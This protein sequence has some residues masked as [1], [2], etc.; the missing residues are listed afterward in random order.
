MNRYSCLLSSG[1]VLA[2]AMSLTHPS[3]AASHRE[4]P[5]I[6]LDPSADITDVYAFRN[7]ND[8]DK[9]VFIMNVI[10]AQEPSSGPNY[11]NFDDNVLYEIHLDTNRNGI[12]EDIV[13]QFR[14]NTEIR[15][16]F[17]D[18]PLSYAANNNGPG[19]PPGI[20]ALDGPGSKSLGLRQHYSVIE[21]RGNKRRNLGTGAMFT[22]PSNIGPRTIP[23]Y[24]KLT[25]QGIYPLK[26]GGRVFSGQRDETFYI[27]LGAAF[28]T[29]NF[30][31]PPI[32]NDAQDGDDSANPFGNDM[33]SGFNVNTIAIEV[34]IR[35]IT[36]DS[37]AVI[38]MYA[39]TSRQRF[40]AL[41]S[42]GSS[43]GFG[44]FIQR[45]R[46]ANPLVN[47]LLI[48]TGQK[49]RWNATNP[50]QE[51][52][53]VDFFLNPRPTALINL[54]FGTNFPT[55]NRTDLIAALLK[56]PGQDPNA[57]SPTNPCSELL[58]LD[59]AVAPTPPE[60]QQRLGGLA[61]DAAGF[62]NGRRPND[63]VTDIVLRVVAG[64]L[65]G[66]VPR[67]GDGVN[68][69]IGAMGSNLTD[70]GIYTVFPFLPT[71]HD[72]RNRQHIDCDEAGAN[73]CD[74][75]SSAQ[76]AAASLP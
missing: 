66:S 14:F 20:V 7:W 49:D 29:L 74:P 68:F 55:S 9:V 50:A 58:R 4:A 10:P 34:P 27:D 24:E 37:D 1:A 13:Y 42:D 33:F 22:V 21:K 73:P 69:N 43:R 15:E 56:Y 41:I 31:A 47:E 30:R 40:Q 5:A 25:D 17:K 32:L 28:D 38:G 44:P 72:G 76:A 23:D 54:V 6:A 16:P 12:A 26:N 36:H 45:A 62:P 2:L 53:F 11:F 67:L 70:N 65:L 52:R 64:A 61:G 8:P 71:P 19:L 51:K 18:L 46:M 75:D 63:D 35:D 57:C 48:G 60:F 39:S 3:F 59:L